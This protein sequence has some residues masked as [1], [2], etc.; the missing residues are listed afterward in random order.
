MPKM[1]VKVKLANKQT[2]T[3]TPSQNRLDRGSSS[4]VIKAKL[5]GCCG[6]VR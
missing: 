6:R 3:F 1:S 4:K 5:K 2:K